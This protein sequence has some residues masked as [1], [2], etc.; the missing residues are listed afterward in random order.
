VLAGK[1]N[2]KDFRQADA[3]IDTLSRYRA[4]QQILREKALEAP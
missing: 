2:P 1:E 4:L 3:L